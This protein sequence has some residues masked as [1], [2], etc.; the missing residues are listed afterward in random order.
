MEQAKSIQFHPMENGISEREHV[1]II[2]FLKKLPK[3]LDWRQY[4]P[5]ALKTDRN[6]VKSATGFTP[7]YLLYGYMGYSS[8]DLLCEKIPDDKIY[9]REELFKFRFQQLQFKE[10]QYQSA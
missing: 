9:T 2:S 10:S 8:L 5:T 6:T 4:L 3:E 1:T 7:Q